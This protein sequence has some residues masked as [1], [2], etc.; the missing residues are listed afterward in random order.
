MALR[1]IRPTTLATRSILTLCLFSCGCGMKLETGYEYRPLTASTAER[2]AYY[3]SPFSPEKSAAEREQIARAMWGHL[4]R[5]FGE[6]F[7]LKEIVAQGRIEARRGAY[8]SRLDRFSTKVIGRCA[9][10]RFRAS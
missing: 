10:E 3:A 2:R 1:K 9:G 7:H 4:G 5:T 8:G 6:F